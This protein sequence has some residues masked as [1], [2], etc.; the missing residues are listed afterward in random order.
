MRIVTVQIQN[1]RALQNV[2]IRFDSVTTLI[3]PNGVGKSTVLRALDWF[4]NSNKPILTDRDSTNGVQEEKIEVGVTFGNL[5]EKDRKALGSY[6]TESIST[7]TVWKTR[8]AEGR[9]VLSANSKQFRGF[10]VIRNGKSAKDR[11]AAYQKLNRDQ[12]H[13]GLP[14]IKS[15]AAC[16]DALKEW[17]ALHPEMLENSLVELTTLFQGFNGQ[18]FL[19]DLFQ[20]VFI[21][22]D[23]RA[24]EISQDSGKSTVSSILEHAIDR[25]SAEAEIERL[26]D[27]VS[28]D[29]ARVYT[30]S[31]AKSLENINQDFNRALHQFASLRSVSIEPVN[32]RINIPKTIFELVIRDGE[33]STPIEYQGHGFQ[34]TLII[35]ALQVLAEMDSAGNQGVI[36]LAIEEPELFQHPTQAQAFAK[37]LRHL[38]EN[39]DKSVQIAYATHSPYFLEA[40]HFDQVRRLT[41]PDNKDAS[42]RV[43]ESSFEAVLDQINSKDSIDKVAG[44]MR[45]QLAKKLP[46][47]LFS[48]KVLLV[49]GTTDA[50]IITGI[51]DRHSP[52]WL[53]TQ[54]VSVVDAGSKT[55]L[56]LTHGILTSL[57]IPTF[58]IFDC[59]KNCKEVDAPGHRKNNRE[60]FEYLKIEEEDFPPTRVVHSAAFFENNLE[61]FL[62]QEWPEWWEAMSE[63]ERE[64]EYPSKSMKNETT[65]RTAT[66]MAKGNHPSFFDQVLEKINQ[67]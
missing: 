50:A 24:N 1:F 20:F 2:T 27:G 34:R 59:D 64:S 42:V 8:H 26:L 9:E 13:L 3:G 45:M 56:A 48:S 39:S 28:D 54:G 21:S 36:F 65:Y 63:I 23:I 53:E 10:D 38:S 17:E 22:A 62:T 41:R 32:H 46:N 44:L 18:A 60:L 6:V 4:F 14:S 33:I 58:V 35:S 49:E 12:P 5:T 47:A 11:I 37:V 52:G 57:G 25:T 51:A 61:C 7:F 19:S 43:Y 67:L 30:E 16:S 29:L 31:F 55:C 15:D 40:V 66:L